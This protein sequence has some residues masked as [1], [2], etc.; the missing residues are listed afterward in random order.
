MQKLKYLLLLFILWALNTQAQTWDYY[1]DFP[2]NVKP[3]DIDV[4]DAGTIFMLSSDKR[5]FYKLIDENWQEM[6]GFPVANPQGISVVKNSNRM[7]FADEFQGLVFT[8]NFGQTWQQT[9]LTT[10]PNTGFHEPLIEISNINNPNLFY[11]ASFD[12]FVSPSVIKY[13]NN[14]QS[15]Q[16]IFYDLTNNSNNYASEI[17]TTTSNRLLIGT[18]NGG[19]WISN[20]NG[21]VFQ[22]TNQTQHNIFQFTEA[23]NGM[24]YA[25]GHNIAQN[26]YFLITSSDYINW[27]PA[28][29]PNNLEK[30]TS[31]FFNNNTQSLWLGSETGLYQS[32]P[33]TTN[34]LTWSDVTFNNATQVTVEVISAGLNTYNFSNQFIAQQLNSSGNEWSQ[35]VSGLTGTIHFAGFG[36]DNRIFGAS[37][38]TN[39]ISFADNANTPWSNVNIT[40]NEL[41]VSDMIVKP[42]G[43]IFIRT[44]FKKLLKSIDNGLSYEEITPPNTT[45]SRL[46]VGEN[47]SLF[48][49]ENDLSEIIYRST[50]DGLSWEVFADFTH[51]D[52]SERAPIESVSEDSNGVIFVTTSSFEIFQGI[53]RVQFSTNQG[54]SWN[55][56]IYEDSSG[57]CSTF[58]TVISFGPKTF[59]NTCVG[60]FTLN[61]NDPNPLDPY[62]FPWGTLGSIFPRNFAINSQGSHY[63]L[64]DDLF[65][66]DDNGITWTNLGRPDELSIGFPAMNGFYIDINDEVYILSNNSHF[67]SPNNRGFYKVTETLG[68]ENQTQSRIGIYPNPTSDF[69]NVLMK[70]EVSKIT[71]YNIL[72]VK[73]LQSSTKRLDV[74]ALPNGMYILRVEDQSGK[75]H[76]SKF[77]KE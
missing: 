41:L 18:E 73:M 77:I 43:K 67:V 54:D 6:P 74:S 17:F 55:S 19:I 65:K 34:P 76:N 45:V 70:G 27:T 47:N 12:V 2:V 58:P 52:P 4:N 61:I 13:T 3:A 37:Y 16:I 64:N 71:V 53:S 20:N 48:I 39:V 26:T 11:G 1:K 68:V 38:S 51:Q 5:F 33:L 36:Q 25:L 75:T 24:V 30:Y 50:D 57:N 31:L 15:G 44:N 21:T 32:G 9:F 7:Y 46:Y 8:D 62:L 28:E 56:V 35:I 66:S 59:F 42:N 69:L 40:G 60:S 72:G 29:L 63:L 14:G 49:V 22:P 23:S 10:N